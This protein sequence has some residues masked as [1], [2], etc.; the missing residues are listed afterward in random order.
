MMYKAK[1]SIGAKQLRIKVN[2]QIDKQTTRQ[3]NKQKT[4]LQ[5]IK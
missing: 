4:D 2:R 1:L 3:T 5:T